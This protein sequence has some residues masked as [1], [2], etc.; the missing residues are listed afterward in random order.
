MIIG[1]DN[2]T[3]WPILDTGEIVLPKVV[4]YDN[5][6]HAAILE[7]G[8]IISEPGLLMPLEI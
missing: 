8:Q 5:V 4:G 3:G 6:T 7:T 2:A 1:Y